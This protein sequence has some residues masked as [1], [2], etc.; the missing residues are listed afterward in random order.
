MFFIDTLGK[1]LAVDGIRLSLL[2]RRVDVEWI[3]GVRA[4]YQVRRREQLRIALAELTAPDLI[5]YGQLA[6]RIKSANES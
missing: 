1:S 4:S 2:T 3:S 5:R 6:N